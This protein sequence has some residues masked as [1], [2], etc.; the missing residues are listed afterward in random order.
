MKKSYFI[1]VLIL[2]F[3]SCFYLFKGEVK[4]DIKEFEKSFNI[5]LDELV[6]FEQNFTND[7]LLSTVLDSFHLTKI[8]NYIINNDITIYNLKSHTVISKN[9]QIITYKN[10]VIEGQ[11]FIEFYCNHIEY[12]LCKYYKE[13]LFS[14]TK[15]FYYID[16]GLYFEYYSKSKDR[17]AMYK[18]NS[19]AKINKKSKYYPLYESS[20]EK[21]LPWIGCQC[22]NGGGAL[23]ERILIENLFTDKNYELMKSLLVGRNLIGRLYAAELLLISNKLG[24]LKLSKNDL[25][26]IKILENSNYRFFICT[27]CTIVSPI[28]SEHFTYLMT[29]LEESEKER[30]LRLECYY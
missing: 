24:Y 23:P 20:V 19:P 6:K 25:L 11:F 14:S 27:G 1:L 30:L 28:T 12:D 7:L 5:E 18:I 17:E 22:G 10:K 9:I 13:K 26:N 29:W 8:D 16:R 4:F 21:A 3:S 2:Y 15:Y